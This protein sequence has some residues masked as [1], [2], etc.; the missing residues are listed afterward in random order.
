MI[1]LLAALR[2]RVGDATDRAIYHRALERQHRAAAEHWERMAE[3]RREDV[4]R[5][6]EGGKVTRD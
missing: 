5:A 3:R 1:P 6:E 4:R 2:D